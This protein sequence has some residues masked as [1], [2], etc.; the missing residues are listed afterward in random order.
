MKKKVLFICTGNACRSQMAEG[1]LKHYLGEVY[2]SCSAGV[3]PFRLSSR[4]VQVMQE[5]SI[6]I[7]KHYAKPIN[8]PVNINPDIVITL[9]D[10]A[11]TVCPDFPGKTKKIH[12]SVSDP[13]FAKGDR[14]E[15]LKAFREVRDEI[16]E[17]ILNELKR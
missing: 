1:L 5:I 13:F 8:A 4:A 7:S 11:M 15:S 9:C 17:R 10:Y 12:W 14:E 6:D 16:K 3:E 2:E